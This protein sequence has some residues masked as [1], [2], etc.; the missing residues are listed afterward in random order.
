[1]ARFRI[2]IVANSLP[3]LPDAVRERLALG[4]AK[5]AKDI[6]ADAK[7]RAPVRTGALKNSIQERRVR[8]LAREINVGVDYGAFVEFGT[9]RMAPRP[10]LT[11]AV[12]AKRATF[13]RLL[14]A[15]TE[16]ALQSE[17]V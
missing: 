16:Q 7:S 17:E 15:V 12:E 9:V 3:D 5:I 8:Q 13:E 4:L 11:P 10:Y 6:E 2:E 1:M 14:A